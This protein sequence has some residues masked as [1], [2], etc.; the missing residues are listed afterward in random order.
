MPGAGKTMMAAFVI[1]H[2]FGT[3]RNVTNGVT[4]IFCNYGEQRDQNATGLRGAILQQLVRAQ[5]LIPEPVLRLYEYHSG[6]GTRSSLQEISDTLHT[7]FSNYSKV[8]V[9]VDT[10]DECADDGTCAKLLT[11]IRSL[12]KESSTDLRLM[13][14][15]RSIPNIEEKSKGEL[16]L[17]VRAS[18]EDVKRFIACQIYRLLEAV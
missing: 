17:K 6:R 1:D 12:Q 9:V 4:Y 13:V 16:T 2:L 18:E 3:I 8:Y 11:T 15:S 5:R 7:I 10:L 14:T